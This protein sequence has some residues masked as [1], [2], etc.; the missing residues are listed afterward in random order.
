MHGDSKPKGD[1]CS[2]SGW[3]C[4]FRLEKVTASAV[5]C[6][7]GSRFEAKYLFI[8]QSGRQW[9]VVGGR[10]DG[11]SCGRR[12]EA[13]RQPAYPV[14][15]RQF[16]HRH[17]SYSYKFTL[18]YCRRFERSLHCRFLKFKMFCSVGLSAPQLISPW[19]LLLIW[20]CFSF[21]WESA[22]P[23]FKCNLTNDRLESSFVFSTILCIVAI[24]VATI[25][26]RACRCCLCPSGLCCRVGCP[27]QIS[28]CCASRF[29]I[30]P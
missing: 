28:S 14:D 25:V 15:M 3:T 29:F 18:C 22:I 24:V 27:V 13:R 5:L 4:D 9:W 19:Y 26:I 1:A 21:V 8:I 16:K 11:G 23:V 2:A 12:C 10:R 7:P 30:C 20:N 17:K 6:S